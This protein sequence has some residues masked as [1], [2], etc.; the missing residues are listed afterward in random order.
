MYTL[1]ATL[2]PHQPASKEMGLLHRDLP[3]VSVGEL[4][5]PEGTDVKDELFAGEQQADKARRFRNSKGFRVLEDGQGSHD[6]IDVPRKDIM[7]EE[8]DK[9][10][11]V[12]GLVNRGGRRDGGK[13]L[14]V[15]EQ[16]KQGAVAG[17]VNRGGRRG[18]GKDVVVAEEAEADKQGATAGLVGGVRGSRDR[19]GNKEAVLEEA[20]KQGAVAGLVKG[21]RRGG[22]DVV[23][24]EEAEADKQGATAGLVR[25]RGPPDVP[26][27][28]LDLTE[29]ADKQGAV[30]GLVKGGRGSRDGPRNLVEEAD[31]QGAV[32][33]LVKGGRR[34]GGRNLRATV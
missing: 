15:E 6:G 23:V 29:E 10:G 12:A 11:A 4:A 34:N 1:T 21:G 26:R 25:P 14:V 33:G 32:A 17:L 19:D 8:Q 24:A 3:G 18:G 13:D 20:D 2:P 31:K 7:V 27:K 5:F 30:A 22:K 16:D 28:D 9:Q